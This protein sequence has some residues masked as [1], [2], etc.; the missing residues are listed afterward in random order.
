MIKFTFSERGKNILI[1]QLTQYK[2]TIFMNKAST[3]N[4]SHQTQQFLIIVAAVAAVGGL[5]FGFDHGVINP[6]HLSLW[7]V[8][9]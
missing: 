6:V 9:D 8:D 3:L 4:K 1:V 2:G 5:V 7:Q